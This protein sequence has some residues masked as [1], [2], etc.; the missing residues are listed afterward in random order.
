MKTLIVFYSRT[1]TTKKIAQSLAE[2]LGA[3]VEEIKDTIDRSG[4][5]GYFR[6]GRDGMK[7]QLTKI[8]PI[9]FDPSGYDLVI[10]GTPNWAGHVSAPIRTYLAE[11]K[12]KISKVAFFATMGSQNPAKIFTDM[13]EVLGKKPISIF[14][15]QTKEAV[16]NEYGEKIGTFISQLK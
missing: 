2:K 9:K 3:D 13:E 11:Q 16:K 5:I 6:A 8:E 7:K 10:V 4:V 1:G 12:E 14:S 15:I